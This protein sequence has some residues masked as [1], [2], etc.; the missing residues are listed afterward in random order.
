M[1]CAASR[2]LPEF[3]FEAG[4]MGVQGADAALDLK[5]E[6]GIETA[7]RVLAQIRSH[8]LDGDPQGQG[9]IGVGK[10]EGV[11]QH[12]LDLLSNLGMGVVLADTPQ[13]TDEFRGKFLILHG[14][15]LAC[16]KVAA[17]PTPPPA[18]HATI[19]LR[20]CPFIQQLYT[21][22]KGFLIAAAYKDTTSRISDLPVIWSE[23]LNAS[24][25]LPNIYVLGLSINQKPFHKIPRP[26]GSRLSE[27]AKRTVCSTNQW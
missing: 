17:Y 2:A 13:M 1:R 7:L 18:W 16:Q 25:F 24:S 11:Q 5:A 15:S 20:I 10:V 21:R 8:G 3:L 26:D 23:I 19:L 12:G 22:Q 9:D 27:G 14:G 6:Q 4:G